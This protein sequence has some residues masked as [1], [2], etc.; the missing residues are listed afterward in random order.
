M[1][2]LITGDLVIDRKYDYGQIDDKLVGL[3]ASSNF[4]ITNLEAPITDSTKKII[5][6]GPHL[7]ANKKST[8]A[9]LKALKIDLV[10]LANNHIKDFSEIGIED[11]ISF[12]KENMI[13]TV[14]AG[15]NLSEARKTF[16]IEKDGN[17]IAFINIAENEWASAT[18]H[19]WG[20]H[21]MDIIDNAKAIIN[22]KANANYV[23]AI[24]HGG[25]EMYN[26][27]S[28]RMQKQY[29]FYT[30]NGADIVVGHHS[31]CISGWETYNGKQIF[32][33]LGN[34]LFTE[35]ANGTDW[36]TGLVLEINAT[37]NNISTKIFPIKVQENTFSLTLAESTERSMILERVKK[38]S[39]TIVDE[40]LLQ[41]EWERFL[42]SMYKYRMADLSPISF[43]SSRIIRG[44]L[45]R[46][47]INLYTKKGCAALL[48]L[49]RCE[50]H[51]D[52]SIETLERFIKN[53]RK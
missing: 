36:Y 48:N 31:H 8:E 12:C 16:Y 32:Y 37:T 6:T 28:P 7:K 2:I 26:L 22:A 13:E 50:A 38:Y 14:G 44:S 5:K 11:T 20:T 43:I 19:T 18:E 30:E 23:I 45:K 39:D 46:M 35:N 34:F 29:R 47:G 33:G 3:F 42:E 4:N 52:I 24:V 10:T 41:N 25:H 51:S 9:V 40:T 21:P 1:K 49:M 27:P 17:K 15:K 53:T